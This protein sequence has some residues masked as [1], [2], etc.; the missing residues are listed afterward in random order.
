MI[1]FLD[2]QKINAQYV[3]ELKQAAM[4]VIDFGWFLL[5]EIL[6]SVIPMSKRVA[7]LI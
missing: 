5:G 1:K 2:L 4:E 6:A 7:I 3:N